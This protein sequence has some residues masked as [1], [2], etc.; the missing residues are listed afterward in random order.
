[1]GQGPIVHMWF[2][3]VKKKIKENLINEESLKMNIFC[4][5]FDKST[6]EKVLSL[7]VQKKFLAST[8]C[9][10]MFLETLT[11]KHPHRKAFPSKVGTLWAELYSVVVLLE[12]RSK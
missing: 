4:E 7:K 6:Q 12:G 9:Q 2:L 1:M 3:L 10:K 5:Y 8:K 11:V